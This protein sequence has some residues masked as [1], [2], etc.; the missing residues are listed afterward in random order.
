M[1]DS[2]PGAPVPPD[3]LMYKWRKEKRFLPCDIYLAKQAAAWGYAQTILL[4]CWL[5]LQLPLG[6]LAARAIGPDPD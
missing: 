3:E 2:T 5:L 1:T 4:L 6:I